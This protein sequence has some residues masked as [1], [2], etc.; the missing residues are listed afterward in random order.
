[1]HHRVVSSMIAAAFLAPNLDLGLRRLTGA[2][3]DAITGGREPDGGVVAHGRLLQ[4]LTK[5]R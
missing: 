3:S 1:M 5:R 2:V 4:A